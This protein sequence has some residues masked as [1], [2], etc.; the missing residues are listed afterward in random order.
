MFMTLNMSASRTAHDVP[1]FEI[2]LT[3]LLEIYSYKN[4]LFHVPVGS[5]YLFSPVDLDPP[6]SVCFLLLYI[7]S[8]T[9]SLY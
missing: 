5:F 1:G 3:T 6:H 7:D 2:V 4:R 9:E 8:L